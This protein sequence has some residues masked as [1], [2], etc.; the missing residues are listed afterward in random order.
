VKRVILKEKAA[1]RLGIELGEV[2]EE[3]IIL[4]QMVGGLIVPPVEDPPEPKLANGS[5]GGFGQEIEVAT[6]Q[7][8]TDSTFVTA[9]DEYWVRVTLSGGEWERLRKDQAAQI[10][11][12]ATRDGL[13][14]ETFALPS[15][16]EP[17]QDM[18]RSMMALYYI[19]SDTDHGLNLYERVRV[20]LQLIGSGETRIIVPYSAVYYDGKGTPWVYVSPEPLVFQRQRIR[21]VG[22]LAVITDGPPVGTKVVTV[23]A[24]LLYG[25]EVVY[26]R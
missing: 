25:A 14:N 9:S 1:E 7:T 17:V 21:I 3:L 16:L 8:A 11:P 19:I 4:K 12:L 22:D 23:G 20:E 10:M 6:V 18:K 26:K 2:R 24:S 13:A 15:D 5:F